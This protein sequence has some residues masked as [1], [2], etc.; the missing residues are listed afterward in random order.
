[1]GSGLGTP[2]PSTS[3]GIS[4]EMKGDLALAGG[5]SEKL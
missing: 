2:A 4:Y 1:M 3:A 5:L